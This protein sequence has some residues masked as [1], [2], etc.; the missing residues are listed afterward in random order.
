MPTIS[1]PTPCLSTKRLESIVG[2]IGNVGFKSLTITPSALI[3]NNKQ[4]I[5]IKITSSGKNLKE[6]YEFCNPKDEVAWNSTV[7]RVK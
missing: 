4:G 5:N 2:K 3:E 7:N 1:F 6:I